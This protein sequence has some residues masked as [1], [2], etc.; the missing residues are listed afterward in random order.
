MVLKSLLLPQ[1]IPDNTGSQWDKTRLSLVH[2]FAGAH[3]NCCYELQLMLSTPRH[4]SST[5]FHHSGFLLSFPKSPSANQGVLQGD[6]A[7][8]EGL[9]LVQGGIWHRLQRE[10]TM[11]EAFALEVA[12]DSPIVGVCPFRCVGRRW[13]HRAAIP[14]VQVWK[15]VC[16]SLY[17]LSSV[18]HNPQIH[19]REKKPSN[20]HKRKRFNCVKGQEIYADSMALPLS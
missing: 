13:S 7:L 16:S 6:D 14:A 10:E 12:S 17:C 19:F 15:K 20:E 5:I 8:P 4:C 2:S 1:L 18:F 3:L 9:L 11:W